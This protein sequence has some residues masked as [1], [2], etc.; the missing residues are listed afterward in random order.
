MGSRP[1]QAHIQA[2]LDGGSISTYKAISLVIIH[3]SATRA[4]LGMGEPLQELCRVLQV[5]NP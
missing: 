4:W 5:L 1:L 3:A 2:V